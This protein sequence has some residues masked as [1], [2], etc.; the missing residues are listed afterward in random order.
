VKPSMSTL[1]GSLYHAHDPRREAGF[2]IFYVAINLGALSGPLVSEWARAGWG[3]RSIFVCAATAMLPALLLLI[4]ARGALG[5]R[6]DHAPRTL[7]AASNKDDRSR[8]HALFL[9]SGVAVIFWLAFQQTGASLAFFAQAHT[10]R[11]VGF[12]RWSLP[13][14]PGHFAALHAGLVIVF[15]PLELWAFGRLR[16]RRAEP[17]AA[18]KMIWGFLFTAAAFAI[19]AGASLC[20]GDT[21]RVSPLWLLSFYAFLSLGELLLSPMGLSLVTELAPPRFSG[22]FTGLWFVAIA[23]GHGLAAALGPFWRDWPHHR[24]FALMALLLLGAAGVI[25]VRLQVLELLLSRTKHADEP[26]QTASG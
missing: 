26:R 9:I 25:L 16:Q 11:R 21:G 3:W 6:A 15:T 8:F 4:A 12:L 20:G 13:L 18:L 22:C 24:Y 19:V 14:R 5:R 10:V 7:G 2:S 1:V 17:S 23:I